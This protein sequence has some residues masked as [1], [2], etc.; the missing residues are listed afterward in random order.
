MENPKPPPAYLRNL[1]CGQKT[2]FPLKPDYPPQPKATEIQN[3]S[4]TILHM[5]VWFELF[6]LTFNKYKPEGNS[7]ISKVGKAGWSHSFNCFPFSDHKLKLEISFMS[8]INIENELI[9]GLLLILK[10]DTDSIEPIPPD[11]LLVFLIFEKDDVADFDLPELVSKM[12]SI[13]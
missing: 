7:G 9:T 5:K 6:I 10:L 1:S 4:F 11:E 3:Q 12:A 13:W 8:S 2:L